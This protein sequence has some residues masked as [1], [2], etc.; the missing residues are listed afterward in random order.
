MKPLSIVIVDDEKAHLDLMKRTI[1]KEFPLASVDYF[2]EAAPCLERLDEIS[3]DVII[4]DYLMPGMNGIE[5]LEVLN[6]ENKDIPVIIITGQGSESIA[7]QAMKLGAWDYL[8]KTHDFF[9]LLPSVIEKVV[10]ERK[11]KEALCESEERYRASFDNFID[12]I[13]IFA[14]DRRFLDVNKKLVQLSGYSKKELLSM[15]LEDLY[16]ESVKPPT[17]ERIQK[18]L[19]GEEVHIF[20]TYFLTKGGEKI[21]VEIGVSALKNCYGQEIVFQGSI[22]NIIERKR[23]Q[24]QVHTL[25]RQLMKAQEAERQRLSRNLHDLVGQDLS[26]LKIGL[27]TLFDDQHEVYPAWRQR[28]AELSKMVKGTIMTVRDLAYSLRPTSLDQV[29]LAKTIFR[30][31]KEFYNRTGVKVEFFAAGLDDLELDSDTEIILYRLIQEGLNNVK[32]HAD[33]TDVTIRLVASFPNIILRIE[34]NGKGFDAEKRLASAINEKRM[35]FIS[36]EERV[37]LLGG[38]MKIESHLMQGTKIFIEVPC[39]GNTIGQ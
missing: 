18:M 24:E 37:A 39:K 20:E 7:I 17:E 29:G 34:D 5:F 14:K 19:Q 33:A 21:P 28:V 26:A 32:K 23:A 35:G 22:R 11:L 2:E 30:Y 12:A 16:P 9:S 3:P 13:N 10:R 36:M 25:S 31:C 6:R 8:V 27:D 4:T 38:K 1:D 15:K